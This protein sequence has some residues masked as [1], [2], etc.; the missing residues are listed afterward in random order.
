MNRCF[1]CFKRAQDGVIIYRVFCVDDSTVRWWCSLCWKGT[2]GERVRDA[3]DVCEKTMN[4]I[5]E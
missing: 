3:M 2:T 4:G 5:Q 1:R